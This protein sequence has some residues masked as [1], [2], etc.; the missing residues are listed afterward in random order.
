MNIGDMHAWKPINIIK[1]IQK[2]IAS[3][4]QNL[5]KYLEYHKEFWKLEITEMKTG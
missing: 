5:I 1:D 3:M 4:K 2:A